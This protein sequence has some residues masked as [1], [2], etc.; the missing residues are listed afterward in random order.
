MEI[1]RK[2]KIEKTVKISIEDGK[3]GRDRGR[4]E[5]EEKEMYNRME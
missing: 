2:R 1:G 5:K 4:E 3:R